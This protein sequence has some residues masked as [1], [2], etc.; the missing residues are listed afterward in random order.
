MNRGAADH[1]QHDGHF[2]K[3]VSMMLLLESNLGMTHMRII[4]DSPY[5]FDR[6][7]YDALWGLPFPGR[8]RLFRLD[9]WFVGASMSRS[10]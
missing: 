4:P 7:V 6:K 2:G 5:I 8:G 3:G 1:Y 9:D 10:G